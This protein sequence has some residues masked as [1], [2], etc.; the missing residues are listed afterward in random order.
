MPQSTQLNLIVESSNGN[1]TIGLEN[2]TPPYDNM[3]LALCMQ[4]QYF[5]VFNR[6]MLYKMCDYF[7]QTFYKKSF[8]KMTRPTGLV[9]KS[10]SNFCKLLTVM[11]KMNNDKTPKSKL[12]C[13]VSFCQNCRMFRFIAASLIKNFNLQSTF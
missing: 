1:H 13:L 12:F 11:T 4:Y 9:R 6:L 8:I 10:V 3:S 2:L 7:V 5:Y